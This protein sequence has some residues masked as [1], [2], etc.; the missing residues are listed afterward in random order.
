MVKMPEAGGAGQRQHLGRAGDIGPPW[1]GI[2]V[3]A[4][5]RQAGSVVEQLVAVLGHPVA[6]GII[7]PAAR[8]RQIAFKDDRSGEPLAERLF[9]VNHE[10]LN[11]GRG[12]LF[13]AAS[14]D[15]G[16]APTVEQ[17]IADQVTAEQSGGAGDEQRLWRVVFQGGTRQSGE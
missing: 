9:P 3:G 17:K 2:S 14:D 6:G 15:D 12:W 11:S 10:L 4:A 1:L 16:E 13:S 8:Q 7:E 5:E